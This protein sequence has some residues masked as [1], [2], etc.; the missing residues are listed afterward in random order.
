VYA[1]GSTLIDLRKCITLDP[2]QLYLGT[3]EYAYRHVSQSSGKRRRE[4]GYCSATGVSHATSSGF[5]NR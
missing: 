2:V 3:K 4:R 1:H 5:P